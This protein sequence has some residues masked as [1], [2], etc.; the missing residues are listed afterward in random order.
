MRTCDKH[1]NC[2]VVYGYNGQ[3]PFCELVEEYQ[4]AQEEWDEQRHDLHQELYDATY[5][6]KRVS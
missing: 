2:V 3:C 4:L 1:N 6:K 5:R